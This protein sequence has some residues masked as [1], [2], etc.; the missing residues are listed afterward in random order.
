MPK[1]KEKEQGF[2]ESLSALEK[3][4]GQLESGDLPLERALALFEEGVVLARQCQSQLADAE[5]KVE[6]LLRE[7]GEIKSIPFE[8][9]QLEQASDQGSEKEKQNSTAHGDGE[10]DEKLNDSIPF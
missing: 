10:N 7:R 3:I 6:L 8:A 2:E 1:S 9:A 5:R 4:V